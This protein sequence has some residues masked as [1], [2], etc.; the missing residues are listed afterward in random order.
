MH[1]SPHRLNPGMQTHCPPLHTVFSGHWLPHAPQSWSVSIGVQMPEQHAW[2]S[3]QSALSG[4]STYSQTFCVQLAF[5]QVSVGHSG[6]CTVPPQPSSILPQALA[7]Q[8][9]A[10]V[11]Q[12]SWK[13]TWPLA[14]HR[15]VAA[16]AGLVAGVAIW[17]FPDAA[18]TVGA[19]I[20][21]ANRRRWAVVHGATLL[22]G[23]GTTNIVGAAVR[24]IRR[25]RGAACSLIALSDFADRRRRAIARGAA[26]FA[27]AG[28]ADLVLRTANAALRAA[29]FIRDA[30]LAA[31]LLAGAAHVA[32]DAAAE[33]VS[34]GADA[35]ATDAAFAA[36]AATSASLAAGGIVRLIRV[37]TRVGR[38]A[39]RDLAGLRRARTAR[40]QAAAV[41]V[42]TAAPAVAGDLAAGRLAAGVLEADL[43]ARAADAGHV[44]GHDAAL[45][46]ASGAVQLLTTLAVVG[47]GGGFRFAATVAAAAI[48]IERRRS[49]SREDDPGG[50][51]RHP[52][53]GSCGSCR[54]GSGRRD[55]DTGQAPAAGVI[56][57]SRARCPRRSC[58]RAG[59]IAT[60]PAF[61]LLR[62]SLHEA[63]RRQ[64]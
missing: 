57:P 20:D 59:S 11:Q 38:A 22:A 47:A 35:V 4:L 31:A 64:C 46:I 29:L 43:A 45:A 56:W 28:A 1:V 52:C 18:R 9:V 54:A 6:H 13:Q 48:A 34:V 15:A 2:P 5:W 42:D 17:Q 51:G 23:A 27:R 33:R 16:R 30:R 19:G 24:A 53:F 44:A 14:Q 50:L 62:I 58:W 8:I 60:L 36:R 10:G 32:A 55:P 37:L 40:D 63:K 39:G 21:V 41:V 61:A 3:P 25:I 12:V 7:G 49:N 26:L